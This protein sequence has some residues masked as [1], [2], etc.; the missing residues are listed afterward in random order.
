MKTMAGG[1]G[2]SC[3]TAIG[4]FLGCGWIVLRDVSTVKPKLSDIADYF[5]VAAFL[6][7]LC[8]KQIASIK[9]FYRHSSR[10]MKFL[11][12]ESW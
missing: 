11:F 10:T 5:T 2:D 4:F 1:I 3:E 7:L 6:P 12:K 8:V 9:L